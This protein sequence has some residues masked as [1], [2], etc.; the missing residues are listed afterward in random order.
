VIGL[1]IIKQNGK[2]TSL[3]KYFMPGMKKPFPEN[4][5]TSL[6]FMK[7]AQNIILTE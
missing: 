5:G 7:D 2:L 1:N 3:M 4:I 6:G